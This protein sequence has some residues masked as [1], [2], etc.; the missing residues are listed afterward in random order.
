[1]AP[2]SC[3]PGARP[4]LGTGPGWPSAAAAARSAGTLPVQAWRPKLWLP[5]LAKLFLPSRTRPS[6]PSW[7]GSGCVSA[8][9]PVSFH[10]V[11]SAGAG[12]RPDLDPTPP[13][14]TGLR[15]ALQPILPT[16]KR[17][18]LLPSSQRTLR[19]ALQGLLHGVRAPGIAPASPYGAP[20]CLESGERQDDADPAPVCCGESRHRLL[21]PPLPRP[22]LRQR[23]HEIPA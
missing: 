3:A 16:P 2:T 23:V 18:S 1:M 4:A 5:E 21:P 8:S 14:G 22:D 7:S 12:I 20:F 17:S 10:G 9:W 11:A 6:F 19:P 13:V 15:P